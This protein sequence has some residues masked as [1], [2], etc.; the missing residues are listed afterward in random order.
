MSE[1]GGVEP[2]ENSKKQSLKQVYPREKGKLKKA[3]AF[4]ELE[5]DRFFDVSGSAIAK[6]A[7]L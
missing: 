5:C 3:I 7:R 6:V 2:S 4:E 1:V